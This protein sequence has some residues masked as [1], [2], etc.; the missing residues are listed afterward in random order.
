MLPNSSGPRYG[1]DTLYGAEGVGRANLR[2]GANFALGDSPHLLAL[3]AASLASEF[4]DAGV[5]SIFYRPG[6]LYHILI[7]RRN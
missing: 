3:I 6:R 4:P 1:Q 7:T 5:G 2:T